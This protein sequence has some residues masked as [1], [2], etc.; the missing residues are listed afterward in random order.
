MSKLTL[1]ECLNSDVI[2]WDR[3]ELRNN[4]FDVNTVRYSVFRD[5]ISIEVTK[6]DLDLID[7]RLADVLDYYLR[8]TRGTSDLAEIIVASLRYWHRPRLKLTP[9]PARPNGSPRFFLTI[10]DICSD[11]GNGDGFLFSGST[12]KLRH[13]RADGI[14]GACRIKSGS[15]LY[16]SNAS[17]EEQYPG[18]VPRLSMGLSIGLNASELA[19]QIIGVSADDAIA[20][21]PEDLDSSITR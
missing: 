20:L 13:Q 1:D 6:N 11:P 8:R 9:P 3:M 7:E 18:S 10:S 21:L 14:L 16:M 17:L 15:G 2:G 12:F 4:G 5:G 19:H